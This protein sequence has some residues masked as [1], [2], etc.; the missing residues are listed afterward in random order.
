MKFKLKKIEHLYRHF[1]IKEKLCRV[2]FDC[3]T[4]MIAETEGRLFFKTQCEQRQNKMIA[5]SPSPTATSQETDKPEAAL[6]MSMQRLTEPAMEPDAAVKQRWEK[7]TAVWCLFPA[8]SISS[9]RH[10]LFHI[11]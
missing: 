3:N 4:S 2:G 1:R 5:V 10:S 8:I 11:N 7:W 6:W 9:T